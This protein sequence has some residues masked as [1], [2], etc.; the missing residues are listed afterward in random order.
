M[1]PR[2]SSCQATV[3]TPVRAL[4]VSALL[5]GFAMRPAIFAGVAVLLAGHTSFDS[6][7]RSAAP[8]LSRDRGNYLL[9]RLDCRRKVARR[10]APAEN[11][12]KLPQNWMRFPGLGDT[13]SEPS[14]P[15]S[16]PR[17]RPAPGTA[18]PRSSC[19][20]PYGAVAERW[21]RGDSRRLTG[22]RRHQIMGRLLAG[23]AVE[24][25]L[26]RAIAG[27]CRGHRPL[28]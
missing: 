23:S 3:L 6:A 15:C 1:T 2:A 12:G 5:E 16:L 24:P 9:I 28:R 11:V 26:L 25:R 21:P 8:S 10:R 22:G 17:S 4:I 13:L 19:R 20:A 7:A 14:A 18:E 27:R